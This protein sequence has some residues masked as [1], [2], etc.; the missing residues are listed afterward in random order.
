MEV[1]TSPQQANNNKRKK[2]KKQ[3]SKQ[4]KQNRTSYHPPHAFMEDTIRHNIAQRASKSNV[5][6][7]CYHHN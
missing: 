2:N 4:T 6:I 1:S 5:Y 3:T 7:P